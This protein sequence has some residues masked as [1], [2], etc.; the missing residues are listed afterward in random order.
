[1][2]ELANSGSPLVATQLAHDNLFGRLCVL[3]FKT[4]VGRGGDTGQAMWDIYF[5]ALNDFFTKGHCQLPPF[6]F[7]NTMAATSLEEEAKAKIAE[8][9]AATTFSAKLRGY[10]KS[11]GWLS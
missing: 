6:F 3:V 8:K 9:L 2:M 11:Q 1:M 7:L 4:G 5:K 10:K